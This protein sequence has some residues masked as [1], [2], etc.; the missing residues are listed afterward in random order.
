MKNW[1][2]IT[3]LAFNYQGIVDVRHGLFFRNGT[4]NSEN[5]L[6]NESCVSSL[7]GKNIVSITKYANT[8]RIALIKKSTKEVILDK[9]LE[10]GYDNIDLKDASI[11][12]QNN[13]NDLPIL[14]IRP[15][16]G[17]YIIRLEVNSEISVSVIESNSTV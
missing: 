2:Q 8:Y 4:E 1:T 10:L 11:F 17:G 15:K 16:N 6:Y 14:I 7:I 3:D 13:S 5:Q 9:P 12:G